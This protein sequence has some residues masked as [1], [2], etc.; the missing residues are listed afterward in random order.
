M[1]EHLGPVP[2]TKIKKYTSNFKLYV[3]FLVVAVFVFTFSFSLGQGPDSIAQEYENNAN[4][5][6]KVQA[7][8]I[9]RTYLAESDNF[10]IFNFNINTDRSG[11]VLYKL[12]FA[13]KGLYDI[14]LMNDLKLFHQSVQLGDI[15]EV[16]SQGNVYFNIA[17]YVLSLGDNYLSLVIPKNDN[18][19]EGNIL[20]VSLVDSLSLTSQYQGHLLTARGDFPIVSGHSSFV[21][22][23][24]LKILSEYNKFFRVAELPQQLFSFRLDNKIEPVEVNQLT[25]VYQSDGASLANKDFVLIYNRQALALATADEKQIVFNLMEPLIVN[26]SFDIE[27]HALSLPEGNYRFDLIDWQAMGAISEKDIIFSE[28]IFLADIK[29]SPYFPEFFN[30]DLKNILSTGWNELYN[31][32][33]VA[34]GQDNL[35]LYKLSW[36]IDTLG[37]KLNQVEVWIDNQTYIAD[38]V[39]TEDKIIVKANWDKPIIIDKQG[40]DIKLL[41]KVDDLEKKAKIE[42]YLLTDEAPLV[43]DNSADNI[44]WAYQDEMYNSYALPY[45]PLLPNI[46]NN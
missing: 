33:L 42:T 29:V 8:P 45:L 9:A 39:L 6:V 14:E 17:D 26:D 20:Q 1:F 5:V 22:Q 13:I 27:L 15:K 21:G 46:L 25:F 38:M 36:V 11:V 40:T 12:K 44:L 2:E 24:D 34:R 37:A 35:S 7:E 28:L 3:S 16:D 43:G 23:G 4:I 10:E 19:N 41:I 32:K 18:I 31:M 30:G